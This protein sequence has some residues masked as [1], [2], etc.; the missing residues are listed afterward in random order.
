MLYF[1]QHAPAGRP[2]AMSVKLMSKRLRRT[3]L[4]DVFPRR[5]LSSPVGLTRHETDCTIK[6]FH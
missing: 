3:S 4:S 1:I 2:P 6:M 5:I